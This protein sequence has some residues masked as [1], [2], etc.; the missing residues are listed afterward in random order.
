MLTKGAAPLLLGGVPPTMT[1]V[2]RSSR[3]PL[4]P[5]RDVGSAETTVL[6]RRCIDIAQR[7]LAVGISID[8]KRGRKLRL[9]YST[10]LRWRSWCAIGHPI[11]L[12]HTAHLSKSYRRAFCLLTPL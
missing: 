4:V 8:S 5:P 6:R 3:R 1:T 9:L 2:V 11:G 12:L 7:W 10:V